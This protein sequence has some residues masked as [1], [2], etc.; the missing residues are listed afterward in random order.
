MTLLIPIRTSQAMIRSRPC[1]G[2]PALHFIAG[3]PVF[4]LF[5]SMRH[6]ILLLS[7]LTESLPGGRVLF[8]WLDLR[9]DAGEQVAIRG[10]SGSA[11]R[12]CSILSRGWA[13]RTAARSGRQLPFRF[14]GR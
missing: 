9:L 11:S 8:E 3:S 1:F 7:G 4:I 14:P 12:R 13:S 5:S 2:K 10:E 6:F